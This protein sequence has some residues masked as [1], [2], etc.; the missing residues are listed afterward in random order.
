MLAGPPPRQREALFNDYLDVIYKREQGKGSDII[1]TN[2]ELLVGLHKFIG[3]ELQ[4]RATR[5]SATDATLSADDYS[6]MVSDFITWNDPFS[7]EDMRGHQ[8]RSITAE[9]GERL[10]LIVEPSKNRFGFELRSIQEFFA[11]CH[12]VDT[13]Q[14][15]DQRYRRFEAIAR[16]PHWQ[17]VALFFAGR[18]GRN[19]QGEASNI[20]EV[21]KDI[22]R[23]SPDIYIRRGAHLAL[24][25]AF[26]RAFLPNRRLQRSLLEVA[27][28]VLDIDLMPHRLGEIAHALQD[29]PVEDIKDHIIPIL[30]KKLD[31]L[32]P[33][34]LSNFLYVVSILDPTSRS[35]VRAI[36]RMIDNPKTREQ[37]ARPLFRIAQFQSNTAALV[38]KFLN[39]LDPDQLRSAFSVNEGIHELAQGLATL[40]RS[41]V[42]DEMQY[43]F[44]RH[45]VQLSSHGFR[46][47]YGRSLVSDNG[48]DWNLDGAD[49]VLRAI[50]AVFHCT[51]MTDVR[52]RRISSEGLTESLEEIQDTIPG[53]IIRGD[54]RDFCR[55]SGLSE[56]DS[57]VAP[58]WIL[59]LWLGEV[60]AESIRGALRFFSIKKS[61]SLVT[62]MLAIDW[63][64]VP[65][66]DYIRS[67]LAASVE[68]N[69]LADQMAKWSGLK[70]FHRW[71]AFR[72]EVLSFADSVRRIHRRVTLSTPNE[73]TASMPP[74][75]MA[76]FSA[77][78]EEAG[79]PHLFFYAAVDIHRRSL[80][81]LSMFGD[82]HNQIS[83][84]MSS[85]YL[86]S[87]TH[88]VVNA[89]SRDSGNDKLSTFETRVTLVAELLELEGANE[90]DLLNSVLVSC[91]EF[92]IPDTDLVERALAKFGQPRAG[93][94]FI[95]VW[96]G[97]STKSLYELM[98]TLATKHPDSDVARGACRII[99]GTAM[100]TLFGSA[101]PNPPRFAGLA[102]MHRA[103]C[104]DEDPEKRMAAA[105]LFAIRKNWPDSSVQWIRRLFVACSTEQEVQMLIRLVHMDT[106]IQENRV[107]LWTEILTS[108]LP[109]DLYGDLTLQVRE[110]LGR[111]LQTTN[112]SLQTTQHELGLPLAP[113]G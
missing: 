93:I 36:E 103:L 56:D 13:S 79:D 85:G 68:V 28:D 106:Q 74:R 55:K 63:S 98:L 2:K 52:R 92:G 72:A 112:Q 24:T 65:T 46:G 5:A 70:G 58:F 81:V 30:E 107:A 35:A 104:L 99:Q 45:A 7:P 73:P 47:R 53:F 25:I 50:K 22:D 20:I 48:K 91:F 4:E 77:L 96:T 59:H 61:D 51:M 26:D 1:T 80:A 23:E 62:N 60:T 34:R 40:Q 83:E 76:T 57:L 39:V 105:G 109:I 108:L 69:S 95:S 97:K 43:Q 15:T 33:E 89:I 94:P 3:Y 84:V 31:T 29:M 90:P 67:R 54:L 18:V 75:M 11:A 41:N 88:S 12:L 19:F 38:T 16:F 14:N 78:Q 87:A 66:F 71:M 37:A 6:R 82:R 49:L 44:L 64:V 9:A 113:I 102:K 111:L 86:T 32:A 17:N 21:C 100:V 27:L 101:S 110:S 8:L 10:V 42:S